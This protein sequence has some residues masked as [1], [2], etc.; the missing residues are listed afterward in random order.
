MKH[1]HHRR[2]ELK[3]IGHIPTVLKPVKK[4]KNW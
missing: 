4:V 3:E 2:H 1:K